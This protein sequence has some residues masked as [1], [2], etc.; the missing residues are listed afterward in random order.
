MNEKVTIVEKQ[1]LGNVLRTVDANLAVHGMPAGWVEGCRG[2]GNINQ[3]YALAGG[4]RDR[5]VVIHCEP[6]TPDQSLK[7]RFGVV[8][9]ENKKTALAPGLFICP[10]QR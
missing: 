10:R 8:N 6:N 1:V 7:R 3:A 9:R 2:C 4:N 5:R